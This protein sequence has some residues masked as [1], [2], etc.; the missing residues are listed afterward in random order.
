[1]KSLLL[2]FAFA[3]LALA[4]DPA[5]TPEPAAP[6]PETQAKEQPKAEAE[7]KVEPQELPPLPEPS[8]KPDAG[9]VPSDVP[10]KAPPRQSSASQPQKGHT[11]L[12]PPMTP[13]DLEARIKFREA[14]SR[15]LNEPAIQALWDESRR[16]KDDANKRD[17][18]RRYYKLF[19][20]RIIAVDK[21]IAQLAADR[22][23][24]ALRRL[25]QS[26]VSPS[27]RLVERVE[28]PN[29]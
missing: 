28:H 26:R 19:F 27:E 2:F 29:D 5:P 3:G 22:R 20:Q 15:V 8:G 12:S 13:A 1:M 6:A 14:S 4:E 11:V 10:K 25:D 9:L 17:A 21:S 23:N 24:I 16:A 18:L 7:P